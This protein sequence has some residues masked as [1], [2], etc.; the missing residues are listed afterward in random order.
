MGLVICARVLELPITDQEGSKIAYGDVRFKFLAGGS[1]ATSAA[2]AHNLFGNYGGLS[3]VNQDEVLMLMISA[4]GGDYR[5]SLNPAGPATND[6][7]L[8]VFA[9]ASVFDLPPLPVS[10]ASQITFAREGSNNPVAFW[11]ALIRTP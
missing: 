4:S 9:A 5:L 7:S 11:T 3:L 1:T 10:A 8:R 6:T 2:T